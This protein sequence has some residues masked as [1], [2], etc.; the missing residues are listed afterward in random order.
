MANARPPSIAL[1]LAVY[2]AAVTLIL[3][4]GGWFVFTH[5]DALEKALLDFFLPES[6]FIVGEVLIDRLLDPQA[7]AVLVNSA[8][9]TVF[10]VVS[11]CTFPLKEWVSARYE[12]QSGCSEGRV[13]Q[14]LPLIDQ[15]IEELKLALFYG[16]LSLGVLRLGLSDDQTLRWISIVGSHVVLGLT[17]AIDF[18][19]PTLARHGY[20]YVHIMRVLLARPLRLALFGTVFAAPPVVV[21]YLYRALEWSPAMGFGLLAAVQ[22]ATIVV[23][24]LAGTVVGGRWLGTAETV[25]PV[26]A[27]G[28]LTAWGGLIGLLVYNA[29]FF[30]AAA[31]AAYHVS[32]VLK[33]QWRLAPGGF[34]VDAPTLTKPSIGLALSLE[35]H[36]PTLR[37]AK[38]G[39]NRVEIRHQG[40]LLATTAFPAFEVPPGDNATQTLTV[41]VHPKG[42]LLE[43]GFRAVNAVRKGGLWN[44]LKGAADPSAYRVTLILPTPTGDFSL[45]LVGSTPPR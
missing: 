34:D 6:W 32:P 19:S 14:E 37:R 4:G 30:G 15:G 17:V 18:I 16:A 24:V 27:F 7:V 33:C 29:L 36:N 43:A 22:L 40:A 25:P 20:R 21:G 42:G 12:R 9:A 39:E 13:A 45:D 10:L 3:G 23:A 35:I 8:V 1:P 38:I 26:R 5:Q 11:L 41:R 2:I 44:A 28:R 31:Q